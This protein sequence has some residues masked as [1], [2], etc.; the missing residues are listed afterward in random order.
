M[1]AD[2]LK[3]TCGTRLA[4]VR[5]RLHDWY[6][7]VHDSLPL[8][9]ARTFVHIGGAQR[10]VVLASQAFTTLVPLLILVATATSGGGARST[11]DR[12]VARFDLSGETADAMRTLFARPPAVTGTISLV[13]LLVLLLSLLNLTRALQ[14]TYEA[15]WGL[16]SRGLA[17]TVNGFAGLSV[18]VTQLIVLAMLA[19]ALRGVPAG[20]VLTTAARIVVG[21]P[22]WW[23]LYYLLL[24]RR[25]PARDL[26]PG[27]VVAAGGQVGVS[28][29]SGVWMPHQITTN[30]LQYGVIGVTFALISWL[31][32]V[33]FAVVMA[34]VVGVEL[35]RTHSPARGSGPPA[36][37]PAPAQRGG[38]GP[39]HEPDLLP[40]R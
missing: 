10:S 6:G 27:A 16:P 19:S 24:S 33:F 37:A 25:I 36:Q 4:V 20:T 32:V 18:A 30:A 31:I 15:A 40:D 21:V 2:R 9:C 17:G 1:S 23:L 8:R 7:W 5:G 28:I 35:A 39:A 14:R 3:R 34:A 26:L 22:V 12:L 38:P 11:G 13:S 29:L